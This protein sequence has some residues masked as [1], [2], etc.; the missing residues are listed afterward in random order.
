[1]ASDRR[2]AV[3]RP[4]RDERRTQR[5]AAPRAV[6][7]PQ[8]ATTGT[9]LVRPGSAMI[10]SWDAS[11]ALDNGYMGELYVWRAVNTIAHA[12]A[13]LPL[14]AGRNLD[15]RD[16]YDPAAPIAR[17]LGPPPDGPAQG[18]TARKLWRWTMV[19]YLVTGRWCWELERTTRDPRLPILG[20]W[21]LPASLVQAVPAAGGVAPFAE[22]R[23]NWNAPERR[24]LAPWEVTYCWRPHPL[25]WRQPESVLQAAQ[26]PVSVKILL[27]RYD[28]AFLRNG[29][30]PA[31][32]VSTAQFAEAE[33]RDRFR[34]Q[35]TSD[36]TGV[37]NAGRTIFNEVDPGD[38]VG[39]AGDFLKVEKLGLTQAEMQ[40]G[41]KSAELKQAICVAFGVPMSMLGDASER[42]FANAD[43]EHTNFWRQTML[44]LLEE[45]ADEINVALAPALGTE[46]VWF[47]T[48]R[49]EALKSSRAFRPI[50]ADVAIA[51][52][53]A[54]VDE[55]RADVGLVPLD[56]AAPPAPAPPEPTP[57]APA[58][59][60][61]PP[62][63][64]PNL[65]IAPT[66]L[67]AE[68][69]SARPGR[70]RWERL[71]RHAGADHD[72][73]PSGH[74]KDPAAK[75]VAVGRLVNRHATALEAPLRDAMARL[76][77]EQ[78]R[79]VRDR[80]V[81]KRGRRMVRAPAGQ[82]DPAQV[83]DTT[84]WATRTGQVAEPT[85]AATVA[86]TADRLSAAFPAAGT[87]AH[88][89]ATERARTALA[90]RATRLGETVA[91]TTFERLVD[92]FQAG[93]AGGE[94]IEQLADRVDRV[95]GPAS[96]LVRAETIA[97]TE[98]IGSFNTA[99][100]TYVGELGPGIVQTKQWVAT[101]DDR[102]RDSHAEIDG[103]TVGLDET[104]SNGLAYPGDPSGDA[105]EVVN[106]RCTALYLAPEESS[107]HPTAGG[108][109]GE[110][111][112]AHRAARTALALVAAGLTTTD[113]LT[114]HLGG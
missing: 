55:W 48:S 65:A 68:P 103:E 78:H 29:A 70:V 76:F 20:V 97:R 71:A 44:P 90:T 94:T 102:T 86:L 61:P 110:R 39:G 82:V 4:D 99:A 2:L 13:G 16:Q 42:T 105:D 43:Q 84:H 112:A 47:D 74:A 19:Q 45:V 18:W 22:F 9:T 113:D 95:L 15:R 8:V 58:A 114:A 73:V 107:P 108:E 28:L 98:V 27:E 30:V 79:A 87:P 93:V 91:R 67:A 17:L 89:A 80:L 85:H 11:S 92:E 46:L 60:V 49:V 96:S 109:D 100:Q 101:P 62:T 40:H 104:F 5:A 25:D 64:A 111:A 51:A 32:V 52:G 69:R 81:G 36:Y 77:A 12:L 63:S 3:V 14:R 31:T 26:L 88:D 53:L 38:G 66:M 54:T 41:E 34:E 21:P 106:C 10:P 23:F 7:A 72:P 37:A 57:A 83:F 35:F 6:R 75:R 24:A 50:T 56:A 33:E 1:M 59:A